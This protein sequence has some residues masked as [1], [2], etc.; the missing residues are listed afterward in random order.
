DG[1]YAKRKIFQLYTVGGTL[2]GHE[3]AKEI[4]RNTFRA[5]V[6]SGR[7][8]RPDDK[9]DTAKVAR[10]TQGWQDFDQLRF[11]VRIG[12]RPPENG[13]PARNTIKEIITP[14]RQAWK[15]PE[16]ID[17]DLVNKPAAGSNAAAPA[18]PAPQ[19][20]SPPAGAIARPQWAQPEKKS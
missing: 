4:S 17:R 8:I 11:M 3:N 2:P 12:M 19:P 13:D 10:H 20:P 5:I 7:G 15:K 1:P 14:E 16:Q 6:E 18:Q 9:S